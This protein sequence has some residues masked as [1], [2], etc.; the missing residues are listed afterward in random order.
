MPDIHGGDGFDV[1]AGNA[2]VLDQHNQDLTD[3]MLVGARAMLTFA[4]DSLADFAILTDMS[5]ACGS[6]VISDGCRLIQPRRHQK[7]V[8]VAAALLLQAGV[9]VVS[10]RDFTTLA[11]LRARLDPSWNPPSETL[12][13]HEHPWTLEHLPGHHPRS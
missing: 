4:Q 9:P 7:G 8:G 13:H 12:D 10:Q 5:A 6:Q 2:T 1:I 3:K 11:L